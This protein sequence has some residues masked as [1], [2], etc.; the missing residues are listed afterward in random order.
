[1][2]KQI[3]DTTKSGKPES[4]H[5]W[6]NVE[7]LARM[8]PSSEEPQHMIEAAMLPGGNGW[9]AASSGEQTLCMLFDDAQDLRTIRLV[10]KESLRPRT[11]EFLLSW[12]GDQG[13]TWRDIAR[14][15]YNF[16][17]PDST[18]E[19]EE[20][21]VDLHGVTGLSLSIIPEISGGDAVASLAE[22]RIA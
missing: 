8:E 19:V 15:Q 22:W 17:S 5:R 9:K 11:Q 3:L 21:K 13:N 20:Y 6:L 16:S 14:Q 18:L 10:F 7:A 2:R 4:E 1:L 12:S